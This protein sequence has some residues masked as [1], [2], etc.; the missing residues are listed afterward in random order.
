MSK[1]CSETAVAPTPARTQDEEDERELLLRLLPMSASLAGLSVGA[2]TLFRL[3]DKAVRLSTFADDL[4]A[5]CAALFLLSTYLIFWALRSH[6]LGRTRWLARLVD[7]VFL[8]A[9]TAL[10][11]V[12]FMLVY[13]LF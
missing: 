1:R 12:G 2:I 4:L 8:V 5:I 7:G 6:A 11:G 13:A 10:V 3:T 9:L